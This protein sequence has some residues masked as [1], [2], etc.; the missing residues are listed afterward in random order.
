MAPAGDAGARVK[1][2]LGARP[3]LKATL[4]RAEHQQAA[5]IPSMVTAP[6]EVAQRLRHRNVARLTGLGALG[7]KPDH[8]S[9]E[10]NLIPDQMPDLVAPAQCQH[11]QTD[12]AAVIAIV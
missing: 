5:R 2:L 8:A 11:K 1:V 4:A 10:I 12:D 6:Q 7:R 9:I 3:P